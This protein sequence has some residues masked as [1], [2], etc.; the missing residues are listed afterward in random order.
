MYTKTMLVTPQTATL[1]LDTKNSNNRPVS[2]S[3]VD[4]YAQEMKQKRWVNNGQPV[5]FGKPSDNLLNAHHAGD[6]R[7]SGS[8]AE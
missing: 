4:R 1:W 6:H 3:T 5:I 8:K 7:C 2:Q